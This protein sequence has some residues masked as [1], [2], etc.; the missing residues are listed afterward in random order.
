MLEFQIRTINKLRGRKKTDN[1]FLPP[2]M[3]NLE[4]GGGVTGLI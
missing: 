1:L 2:K 3:S 4:T